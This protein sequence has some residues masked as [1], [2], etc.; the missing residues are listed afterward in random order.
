M[1]RIFARAVVAIALGTAAQIAPAPASA[2][3]HFGISINAGDVMF[4]YRDGYWDR[5][6]RWHPWRD[7][8]D[9]RWYRARY[10]DHYYDWRHDRD[11]D[12]GWRVGVYGGPGFIAPPVRLSFSVSDVMFAYE[13]GY[14]DRGHRWHAWRDQ[15]EA[16][17][18][19]DHYHDRYYDWRHDRDPDQGWHN[20]PMNM[21]AQPDNN[22]WNDRNPNQGHD[23]GRNP[24]GND[25]NNGYGPPTDQTN[26]PNGQ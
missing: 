23:N 7:P 15:N 11:P 1:N 22:K 12:L 21:R 19:R 10:R 26:G 13:D 4:A 9:W 20:K 18:W 25:R 17:W 6:H 24:N 5:G 2:G 8:D 3:V 16:R 14:W